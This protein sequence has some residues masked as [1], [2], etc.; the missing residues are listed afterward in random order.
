MSQA[1]QELQEQVSEALGSVAGLGVF[2]LAPVQAAYPFATVDAGLETD[3]GHK[4]GEGREVRLAVTIR[5][6]AERPDRIQGL[7]N[8]AAAAIEG[9]S[10]VTPN[11]SVVS[12]SF[13]RCRTVRESSSG[14]AAVIEYRARMLRL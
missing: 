8:E 13:M 3:W 11:W 14:W 2:A 12:M 4:G 9:L 7:E 10:G 5:D 6:R 1:G